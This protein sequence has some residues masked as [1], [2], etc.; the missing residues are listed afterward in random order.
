MAKAITSEAYQLIK[1]DLQRVATNALI[2]ALP[3]IAISLEQLIAG[4]SVQEILPVLSVWLLNTLL[5]LTRKF[6]QTARYTA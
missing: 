4:K 6:M 1:Q 2:F 3:A 5:D